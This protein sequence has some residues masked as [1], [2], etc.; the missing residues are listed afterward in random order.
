LEPCKKYAS[1]FIDDVAVFSKLLDSHLEHLDSTL[2]HIEESGLTLN[3]EKCSFFQNYVRFLGRIV[4]G[5]THRID[6]DNLKAIE[7]LVFPKTKKQLRSVLGLINYYRAYI[8]HLAD[9]IKPLTEMVKNNKPVIL[10]PTV[11][12]V[13]A[14][15][16]IKNMLMNA[17]ILKCPDF[18]KDFI[19]QAD[20]SLHGS[21]CVLS[22]VFDG[23]EYPICY[24]SCTFTD[25]QKKWTIS[26]LECYGLMFAL[27]RFDSFIYGRNI[28]IVTDHSA[29]T[30]LKNKSSSNPRLARWSL[31]LQRYDLKEIVHRKGTEFGHCDAL[32]RLMSTATSQADDDP[33]NNQST[34]K[35]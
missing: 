28:T 12:A 16:D 2:S 5:G 22:Q 1:S 18:D 32:S 23:N 26:E 34:N 8:D 19:V 4:G 29:L 21:G 17:P 25:A 27:K 20:S 24:A 11:E 13:K 15:E 35:L 7:S 31:A 33:S 14:F 9:K 6:P 10:V 30:F 3:F